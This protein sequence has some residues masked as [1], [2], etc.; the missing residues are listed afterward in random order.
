MLRITSGVAFKSVVSP[1]KKDIC[2]KGKMQKDNMQDTFQMSGNVSSREQVFYTMGKVMAKQGR[3]K[4]ALKNYDKALESNPDANIYFDKGEAIMKLAKKT[5]KDGDEPLATEYFN[6]ALINLKQ[7]NNLRENPKT[8]YYIAIAQ[9]E[10]KNYS[11]AQEA[12]VVCMPY[13]KAELQENPDDEK[14]KAKLFDV[15]MKKGTCHMLMSNSRLSKESLK[16]YVE[17]SRALKINP[18]SDAALYARSLVNF[19]Q[20]GAIADIKKAI[21]INPSVAEY[22][23]AACDAYM[24]TSDKQSIQKAVDYM[25]Q[26]I[27]LKHQ[28]HYIV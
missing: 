10:L 5:K 3:Y 7:S 15:Y 16:A 9:Y 27:S 22:Y 6:E 17:F 11:E 13:L 26:A 20:D 8:A 1:I 19:N 2:F 25:S 24:M 21:S 14:I 4:E 23:D 28:Y 12:F 18:N